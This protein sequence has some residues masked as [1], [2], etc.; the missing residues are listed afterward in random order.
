MGLGVVGSGHREVDPSG[1]RRGWAS[2][3]GEGWME[4]RKGNISPRA[5]CRGG[6]F[7]QGIFTGHGGMG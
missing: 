7:L 4:R 6:L 3:W 5:G 1:E 2:L